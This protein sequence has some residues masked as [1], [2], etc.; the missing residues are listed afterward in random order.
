M[1]INKTER[2]SY[3]LLH[4]DMNVRKTCM[5]K[6]EKVCG[7]ILP[8]GSLRYTW[9][10]KEVIF[11]TTGASSFEEKD[12]LAKA[13][14]LLC[15]SASSPSSYGFVHRLQFVVLQIIRS[16]CAGVGLYASMQTSRFS[17]MRNCPGPSAGGLRSISSCLAMRSYAFDSSVTTYSLFEKC[18]AQKTPNSRE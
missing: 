3:F 4:E 15:S 16:I 11:W 14:A 18:K 5:C 17:P 9:K 1:I 10:E 2:I 13:S 12:V 6:K 7:Y 8:K